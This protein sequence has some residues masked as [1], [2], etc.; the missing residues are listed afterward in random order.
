MQDYFKFNKKQQGSSLF[1]KSDS[2]GSSGGANTLFKD[3]Q[4]RSMP[5]GIKT[6]EQGINHFTNWENIANSIESRN[7]ARFDDS[8]PTCLN[9]STLEQKP[10]RFFLM[11]LFGL[12]SVDMVEAY[13]A[14]KRR[15]IEFSDSWSPNDIKILDD[16]AFVAQ[17]EYT[18]IHRKDIDLIR[19][20]APVTTIRQYLEVETSGASGGNLASILASE[21]SSSTTDGFATWSI[22]GAWSANFEGSSPSAPITITYTPDTATWTFNAVVPNDGGWGG[23]IT[24]TKVQDACSCTGG[25]CTTTS[26]SIPI[27]GTHYCSFSGG[28]TS[29]SGTFN[30]TYTPSSNSGATCATDISSIGS[31]TMN[32]LAGGGCSIGFSASSTSFNGFTTGSGG[33]RSN[34]ANPPDQTITDI[35]RIGTLNFIADNLRPSKDKVYSAIDPFGDIDP[36]EEYSTSDFDSFSNSI[37]KVK[38]TQNVN[39]SSTVTQKLPETAYFIFGGAVKSEVEGLHLNKDNIA[40]RNLD[41]QDGT[42]TEPRSVL[43]N[44]LSQN[45]RDWKAINGAPERTPEN[46]NISDD[47][48]FTSDLDTLD[49][50]VVG[51]F[52]IV[53]ETDPTTHPDRLVTDKQSLGIQ[54]SIQSNWGQ[55]VEFEGGYDPNSAFLDDGDVKFVAHEIS[56]CKLMKFQ[57][58]R[59]CGKVDI[60]ARKTGIISAALKNSITSSG[61]NLNTNDVIKISSAV[62]DGTQTGVADIHPLNGNKFVKRVDDDTFEI[63]EDQFFEK[64]T[65][66]DKL[67]TTDGINWTCISNN[68]GSIGQSWDYY[69]SM[70]SPTGR[71]GYSHVGSQQSNFL[72]PKESFITTK[73]TKEG[74][75]KSSQNA[76]SI[77]LPFGQVGGYLSGNEFSA[78]PIG[79]WMNTKL[80]KELEENI[81]V[82]FSQSY[83]TPL[84]DPRKGPQDFFPYHCQDDLSN[85]VNPAPGTDGEDIK[86]PY[87]GM[88]FGSSMDLKFSHNSG[89]SKVYTLAV[90]ERGSDVSVDIHGV[91]ADEQLFEKSCMEWDWN[92]GSLY[93]TFGKKVQPYYLPYGKTHLISVTVD[94]YGRIS[95]ISHQDTVFGGGGSIS[96]YGEDDDIGIEN[97]PWSTFEQNS[98][99]NYETISN[100]TGASISAKVFSSVS[101]FG[102][103][104]T[105]ITSPRLNSRYWIRS[106]VLHWVGQ[107]ICDRY[108]ARGAEVLQ[109][110]IVA[111]RLTQ[112]SEDFNSGTEPFSRFG[113]NAE[114]RR[115]NRFPD[116]LGE[117]PDSIQYW[118]IF[119]WV[120]SFG[121]S[122]A[123]ENDPTLS[124]GSLSSTTYPQSNP[125]TIILSGSRT[126]SNIEINNSTKQP[127]LVNASNITN[128]ETISE[129]GQIT[130]HFLYKNNSNV[131]KNVDYIPFNSGG[132]LGGRFAS[133]LETFK[134]N[135]IDHNKMPQGTA[136]GEGMAE[137]ITSAELSCSNICWKDNYIVW[138]EQDLFNGNSIVHFFT[139]DGKFNPSSS[140]I[141]PFT[142]NR[143]SVIPSKATYVGE[144]FGIHFKYEDRLFLSNA[145]DNTD[146][147]GNLI[148]A[149]RDDL[150]IDQLFIYELLRN[151]SSFN[152][153]QKIIA[154][155]DEGREDYYSEYFKSAGFLVPDLF[156]LQNAFNYDNNSLRSSAWDIDLTNRYDISGKKIILKDVLEYAVF[157]RDFSKT[158][159][160][161]ISESTTSQSF[162][163]LAVSENSTIRALKSSTS[164]S[165]EYISAEGL[166]E[167]ISCRNTGM[168]ESGND[169]NKTPVLY[170]WLDIDDLTMVNDLTISFEVLDEDIFSSFQNP[171]DSFVSNSILPRCVLYGKDPRQ[172]IIENGP[173]EKG[174]GLS[175]YP[176]YENGL[177][178]RP[179]WNAGAGQEYY[180]D[181]YPGYYRGGAQDL[182]FYGRLPGSTVKTGK[183]DFPSRSSLSYLYGGNVNLGEYYDLTSGSRGNGTSIIAGDPAWI[184]PDV[185]QEFSADEIR[186]ILPYAK[187][188]APERATTVGTIRSFGSYEIKI[189]AEDVR[190]FAI[191]GNVIKDSNRTTTVAG[192][193]NDSANS[194]R[195]SS[196]NGD[197]PVAKDQVNYTLAIG[198]LL[199][200]VDSY[201][202]NTGLITHSEPG[203]FEIGPL[204]YIRDAGSKPIFNRNNYPDARYPYAN[205]V[206]YYKPSVNG[207]EV[208]TAGLGLKQLQYDLSAKI[209]NPTVQ[210][211]T[212]KLLSRRYKNSFHKIAAFNYIEA[213]KDEVRSSFLGS[214][215]ARVYS[216]FGVDRFIPVPESESNPVIGVGGQG[217]TEFKNVTTRK[218]NPVIGISKSSASS[219]SNSVD[220]GSFSKSLQI[221][222]TQNTYRPRGIF[223]GSSNI[224][225]DD[226]TG[227]VRFTTPP[228]GHVLGNSFF[229]NNVLFGGFDVQSPEYLSLFM[230]SNPTSEQGM[231]LL[232]LPHAVFNNNADLFTRGFTAHDART[233][234]WIGVKQFSEDMPLFA[235]VADIE[236]R[237][238][239]FTFEVAPSINSPLFVSGPDATGNITLTITPPKTKTTNLF[240]LGPIQ[241][242]GNFSLFSDGHAF[243]NSDITLNISGTFFGTG[244]TNL[245]TEASVGESGSINLA[246]NPTYSGSIPLYINKNLEASGNPTLSFP[247]IEAPATGSTSLVIGDKFK[248][249]NN[250][251]TTFIMP[252]RFASGQTPLYQKGLS[253]RDAN[254]QR[255]TNVDVAVSLTDGLFD[256]G[257]S[258]GQDREDTVVKNIGGKTKQSNSVLANVINENLY[259]RNTSSFDRDLI[260]FSDIKLM[261]SMLRNQTFDG[262]SSNRREYT[263]P[264]YSNMVLSRS[265][266]NNLVSPFYNNNNL[267]GFGFTNRNSTI[268]KEAY[269]A[270]DDFLV[271]AAD[272]GTIIEIGF[273]DVQE[274]GNVKQ[275]DDD[276]N[277]LR[278]APASSI[279]T[280]FPTVDGASD[281]FSEIRQDI[282]NRMSEIHGVTLTAGNHSSG[283]V[284]IN[285]LKISSNNRCA[286]SFRVKVAYFTPDFFSVKESVFNVILTFRIAGYQGYQLEMGEQ[287]FG[288]ESDYNWLIFEESGSGSSKVS[289]GYNVEFDYQDIYFNRMGVGT[290]GQGQV[291]R[292]K[293]SDGYSNPEKVLSF[294][295]L[296]DSSFYNTTNLAY[297]DSADRRVGFGNP[298]KIFDEYGTSNK[299]MLVGA[300][301]FDPYVF[302]TLDAQHT[303]NAMGAVYIYKKTLV[304]GEWNYHGA[305]YSKGF[306][307]ENI[308]SNLSS[309]RGGT[310]SIQQ[311]ALFGYDFDY[312]QGKIVVTEPGGDGAD[313]VNAGKAYV[314]DISSAPVLEK[315]YLAS[316]ISLPEGDSIEAGDNFGSNVVL[317]KNDVITWSDATLK[318]TT[319]APFFSDLQFENSS[320]IYNLSNGSVFGFEYE[321]IDGVLTFSAQALAEEFDGYFNNQFFN[322]DSF[323][324][325]ARIL[326]LKK[327]RT[328]Q[329]DRLLVVREFSQ[330]G[331]MAPSGRVKKLSVLNLNRSPNGT[332]FISG[333]IQI[334]KDS[335]L[336]TL[337]PIRTEVPLVVNSHIAINNNA[338]LFLSNYAKSM[339]LYIERVLNPSMPLYIDGKMIPENASINL[340]LN[341]TDV[342]NDT[343]L[344]MPVIDDAL[345]SISTFMFGINDNGVVNEGSLFIGKEIHANNDV[346]LFLQTIREGDNFTPGAS[347]LGV[348][349][350][351]ATVGTLEAPHSTRD[352]LFLNAQKIASG[353]NQAPLF[354][355]VPTPPKSED[356]SFIGSGTTNL[357]VN[358]NNNDGVFGGFNAD[359]TLYMLG[360]HLSSG[361]MPLYMERPFANS[362]DLFIESRIASGVSDLHVDGANIVTNQADLIIK[363]PDA[364]NITTFTRGFLE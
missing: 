302:N 278:F 203:G 39:G 51:Y 109:R 46:P 4:N 117:E 208:D 38:F 204:R 125:K 163:Y 219:E 48:G 238:S 305:V 154:C 103:N 166:T 178:T 351:L 121:K 59:K 261:S 70:F 158:E 64:P 43:G 120:D 67:K 65:F 348:E 142:Q 138:S 223:G 29:Y 105:A 186:H 49:D 357:V 310:G 346:D 77:D 313:I 143:S 344:F 274:D 11:D 24:G 234:L 360:V 307:S 123:I 168:L 201:D 36:T 269:D 322:P 231:D 239:L 256:Q 265:S 89:S 343:S 180:S 337:A 282:L 245:Y 37:L 8:Q 296:N 364:K 218:N 28:S 241:D 173:A 107:D 20:N 104:S 35:R 345:S 266:S 127:I 184:A 115:I 54:L 303:P 304:T 131:Y 162:P 97:N 130:A 133:G 128:A 244:I 57:P 148:Q 192:D 42:I 26:V 273:Y 2:D 259:S 71:N 56:E 319:V 14:K 134:T 354:V 135:G 106:A 136:G 101:S 145:L 330:R 230:N 31:Y 85:F 248:I 175:V 78:G 112:T 146:E 99:A 210:I 170:Y 293:A 249:D 209:R 323:K 193:F 283:N 225:I 93:Q 183:V 312:D 172:T 116:D 12:F 84:D 72:A 182:F 113:R 58:V 243:F 339:P 164:L 10:E 212:K 66:T 32:Y 211:S 363:P 285:D 325:S 292:A 281:P 240:S 226:E 214:D 271:K 276:L 358:G 233:D 177:F 199:T 6:V 342:I 91:I 81:P 187:I 190:N 68:F 15:T 250:S 262:V 355:K 3:V 174:D 279:Q 53:V 207:A 132:S 139:F 45:F 41:R 217:A 92:S 338:T 297:I 321:N 242:S 349:T 195:L 320:T 333:P 171:F 318:Q 232:V 264:A 289:S 80:A 263:D 277:I 179:R 150:Y 311:C 196:P 16:I 95:D 23:T 167:P 151:K 149:D 111:N 326:S 94:R 194:I 147:G 141:K 291:W 165:Y 50:L 328:Q 309:Y 284:S 22:S 298:I 246:M 356:G 137:V 83:A 98:R 140:I 191:R 228:T 30:I 160:F 79:Y 52:Y 334:E 44:C 221:I 213:E 254:S 229:E 280:L 185:Y 300:T 124:L 290:N 87:P 5:L 62:F 176:R 1:M 205:S 295:D 327:F 110:N 361:N 159:P 181:M 255:D 129:I 341:N 188:F 152:F 359:N 251:I 102:E 122:V 224:Y 27:T 237:T 299:I 100:A 119:P 306:T 329:K 144:G 272:D 197:I 258:F 350:T 161:S 315:T 21:S 236:S 25:G 331:G 202:M 247:L 34:S 308:L 189:S 286:I 63:Y 86:S 347:L 55:S 47:F 220:R 82:V 198:F 200:N 126:R 332:L 301:L 206:N 270:N 40:Y 114:I 353:V 7:L 317:L 222:N 74:I 18:D 288:N 257:N 252:Q 17:D 69:G 340:L 96:K 60:Y 227:N 157:D 267:T 253:S 335:P 155:I 61:H 75:S 215:E 336:F 33:Q 169:Q 287:G 76:K 108:S 9:F 324:Q 118:A 88:R 73:R 90:G 260:G 362:A 314:F 19:N 153:S 156:P 13:T 316:D 216:A 268:K 294:S 235:K 352:V 275:R